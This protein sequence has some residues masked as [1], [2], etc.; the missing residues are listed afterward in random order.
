MA[1]LR[2]ILF[3]SLPIYPPPHLEI[4]V[5]FVRYS[6]AALGA[7]FTALLASRLMFPPGEKMTGT[8]PAGLVIL[9][10][11]AVLINIGCLILFIDHVLRKMEPALPDEK[12]DVLE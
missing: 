7:I 5:E 11:A 8:L 6:S 12:K 3:G 9:W 4:L 1:P 2:R 10:M